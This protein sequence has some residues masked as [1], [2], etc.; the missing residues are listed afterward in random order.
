MGGEGMLDTFAND[1]GEFGKA[2]FVPASFL[3][4]IEQLGV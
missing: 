1:Y 2:Y 3:K 4:N